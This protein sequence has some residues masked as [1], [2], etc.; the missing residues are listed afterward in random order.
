MKFI[1]N[2]IILLMDVKTAA[3]LQKKHNIHDSG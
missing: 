3:N 2:L 1:E